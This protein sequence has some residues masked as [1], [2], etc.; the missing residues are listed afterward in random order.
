VSDGG[1]VSGNGGQQID[2]AEFRRALG[3]FASGITVVTT[4]HDGQVHGM[5]ANGFMSVSLDPPLVVVSL[6]NTSRLH[7]LLPNSGR[8]GVSVLSESQEPLSKHFA[9]QGNRMAA[10]I[11]FVWHDDIPLLEGALTHLV[12]TVVD[13]HL[14]GDHTLYVG[15]VEHLE[16]S[17]GSPLVFYTGE[18]GRLD[19]QLWDHS[20]IWKP[21]PWT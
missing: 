13:S 5:T 8:Y 1:A 7:S 17:N 18:Y 2:P 4:N 12:C 11:G 14:A 15:R 16:Y 20:Y 6:A 9:A 3:R 21:D 10:E 19:V